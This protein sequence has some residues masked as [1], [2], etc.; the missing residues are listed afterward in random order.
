MRKLQIANAL[1]ELKLHLV[2]DSLGLGRNL[3]N[4][5]KHTNYQLPNK[6]KKEKH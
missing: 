6:W 1:L 2:N 5:G 4:A 3:R